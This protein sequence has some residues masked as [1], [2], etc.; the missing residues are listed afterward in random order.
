L[1]GL[2]AGLYQLK[3][4]GAEVDRFYYASQFTGAKYFA[5][6][7]LFSSTDAD[8]AYFNNNDEVTAKEYSIAFKHRDTLW[9]YK[10]IN[11]NKLELEDPGIKETETPWGFSDSGNL[12]FV[13]DNPMPLKETPIHGI[14][15]YNDKNDA[16]TILIS[17]LP[18]PG[19]ALIKPEP[20]NP[21]TVYSDIYIYL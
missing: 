18:N 14:A 12:I 15:F 8:Y 16:S 10:V 21:A 17:D 2:P 3:I 5:V 13:S 11:R 20:E 9:R 4:D 19:T 7:E 6:I 1:A